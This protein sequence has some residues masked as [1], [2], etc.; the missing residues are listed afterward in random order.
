MSARTETFNVFP[1]IKRDNFVQNHRTETENYFFFNVKGRNSAK[2]NQTWTDI[3]LDLC[4]Y[5]TYP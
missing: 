5:L 2:N 1:T 3:E 4:I